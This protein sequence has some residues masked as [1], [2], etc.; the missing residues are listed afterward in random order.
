MKTKRPPSKSVLTIMKKYIVA[1]ALLALGATAAHAVEATKIYSAR[2]T[3]SGLNWAAPCYDSTPTATW[4]TSSGKSTAA[5]VDAGRP[6]SFY[7]TL[8]TTVVGT[9]WGCTLGTDSTVGLRWLV[10]VTV[11]LSS[12][13][14]AGIYSISS[15][16]STL[17]QT[18]GGAAATQTAA[19]QSANGGNK[20]GF[21]CFIKP[22]TLHP[23]INFGYLS[24]GVLSERAQADSIMFVPDNP[25]LGT[26]AVAIT[27][28]YI[29]NMT[30]FPVTGVTAGA[31][32]VAVY[33]QMGAEAPTLVGLL[34]TGIVAGANT[35]PLLPDATLE[36]NVHIFATQTVAGQ[37][38]CYNLPQN[39]QVGIGNSNLKFCFYMANNTTTP[40]TG[41][42]GAIGSG[43]SLYFMPQVMN[44]AAAFPKEGVDIPLS[45][46]WQTVTI[47]PRTATHGNYNAGAV[48][49]DPWA[50]GRPAF[51]ALNSFCFLM[52]DTN[53]GPYEVYID[54]FGNGGTLIHDWEDA[55]DAGALALPNPG[56]FARFQ[57]EGS[58]SPLLTGT[59]PPLA[60]TTVSTGTNA[61]TPPY[62]AEGG[63]NAQ[64]VKWQWIAVSTVGGVWNRKLCNATGVAPWNAYPQVDMNK[65][66]HF[67]ILLAPPGTTPHSVGDVT[68]MDD[69]VIC[70]GGAMA[71]SVTAKGPG[72]K[73]NYGQSLARTYTYQWK[74]NGAEI[75]TGTVTV[76]PTDPPA[77]IAYA[78]T[79]VSGADA[80]TYSVVVSDGTCSLT[81]SMIATIATSSVKIDN[82]GASDA[83]SPLP[84]GTSYTLAVSASYP[85]PCVCGTDFGYQWRKNGTAI[86]G[87]TAST[88]NWG[89][90]GLQL[91]DAGWYSVVVTNTCSGGTATSTNI[92]FAV[93]DPN[94]TPVTASCNQLQSGLLGLYWTNQT[95]A[96]AFT[97]APTWT[98]VDGTVNFDW[99]LA[100]PVFD[101]YAPTDNFAIRWVAELQ[102]PYNGQTYTFYVKSDDGARLWVNGQLLV[103]KWVSQA[104]TEW[105][106]SIVLSSASPVDLVLQYYEGAVTASVV[107]SY[108]SD[109]IYKTVIPQSQFCAVDPS[110]GIPPL[111][112]L[113]SPANN[114][115]DTLPTPVTLT[116]SV[117]Q[118]S[119]TVNK[120]EFY[121]SA[122]LLATVTQTG[123]GNYTMSW[124]PL[125][126]GVYNITARTYYNTTFTLNTAT[127]KLTVNAPLASAVTI[128]NISGTTLTYGG[129]AGTQFIL[130]KSATVN[131]LMSTW[132]PVHTNTATPGTFTIPAVG[133]DNTL[134]Y[135]IQ[136]K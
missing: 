31:T 7:R 28:P 15:P 16:N 71:M 26:T 62:Y 95:P 116:A 99:A 97:G 92:Q 66:I 100:G 22:T 128:S 23:T 47:D 109:S 43:G 122:T 54:N 82:L 67:D 98:N 89:G 77:T 112:T 56:L 2:T 81:R 27:A 44:D 52:A 115:T 72:D 120:V 135:R 125:T 10:Y 110:T 78:K 127:N 59:T 101:V 42:I 12:S 104:A 133:T 20:W 90:L 69:M 68:W 46:C 34:D 38:G 79:P 19:F 4:A 117:T 74:K 134:F 21:V 49:G 126:A 50:S 61:P 124:T 91:S 102:P 32:L 106:G 25:C 39:Y 17:E 114:A 107:L 41:P 29:T 48:Q 63:T 5:G 80:G 65:P 60:V 45:S 113:T 3:A 136:S 86:A 130:L 35:V 108:S 37:E 83:G 103:D 121:D 73:D 119:A 111:T 75:L 1:L 11:P 129:G 96:N 70:P 18:R 9:G 30:E 13:T 40:D 84:V 88:Y 58:T 53:S 87:A 33:K 93:Y 14:A 24:G 51:Q 94:V 85:L 8:S 132:T 123:S 131:A 118:E 105:S 64:Y 76:G 57:D 55:I 6:G 36:K